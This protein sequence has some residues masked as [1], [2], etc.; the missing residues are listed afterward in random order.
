MVSNH[1]LQ[2]YF[3]CYTYIM[4]F[5]IHRIQY[6]KIIR[7]FVINHYSF[8]SRYQ[9][10]V[11]RGQSN[12]LYLKCC[13]IFVEKIKQLIFVEMLIHLRRGF[14]SNI[15][16]NLTLISIVTLLYV[17][18]YTHQS[19]SSFH[20]IHLYMSLWK[21]KKKNDLFFLFRKL[22]F[23]TN[24]WAHRTRNT[25]YN[26]VLYYI[27]HDVQVL[28]TYSVVAVSV[29]N[30]QQRGSTTRVARQFDCSVQQQPAH[31]KKK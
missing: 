24:S 27:M 29:S 28:H 6:G 23:H 22:Y 13:K 21:V 10:N 17:N 2:K 3:R 12:N 5:D 14:N 19:K 25:I 18:M 30:F 31:K 20:D 1:L 16:S 8:N 9:K 4:S 26:I 7:Y 11:K 15:S